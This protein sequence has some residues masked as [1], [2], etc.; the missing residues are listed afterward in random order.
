MLKF[1]LEGDVLVFLDA[2]MELGDGWLEPY[3]QR[4]KEDYRNVVIPTLDTIHYLH[5]SVYGATK[6]GHINTMDWSL[7]HFF[8]EIRF[9]PTQYR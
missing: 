8:R 7:N 5:F 2:H 9:T 6:V 3:L 4:I 1:L